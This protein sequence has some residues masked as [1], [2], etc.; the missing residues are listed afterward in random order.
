MAIISESAYPTFKETISKKELEEIYTPIPVE[1][2][3]AK[4]VSRGESVLC[5]LI[6]LKAFQKLGYFIPFNKIP[7]IIIEHISYCTKIKISN[8]T[9]SKYNSSGTKAR[10]VQQIRD[11]LN[12]KQF[13]S[14][15]RHL[16]I[17]AM[18][19]AAKTK[20]EPL[21]LINIAIEELIRNYYELPFFNSLERAAKRVRV[22]INRSYYKAI[23][24]SIDNI[25]REKIDKIIETEEE[26]Q[27]TYWN[28]LKQDPSNPTVNHLKDLVKHLKWLKSLN[29]SIKNI[30]NIPYVKIKQFALEAKTLDASKMKQ[31]ESF[32]RY[33]LMISLIYIQSSSTVD[34]IAEMLIKR[35]MLI[36][37]KGKDALDKYRK[38]HIQI[39]DKLISTLKNVVIAYQNVGT[40]EEKFSAIESILAGENQNILENCEAHLSFSGN[41]YYSFL[42]NYF[43]SHRIV[44]FDIL[45]N[46]KL[47]STNQDIST[48]EAIK[49]LQANECRRSDYIETIRIENKGKK[50]EKR[51]PLLNLSW[52]SELW[53]KLITDKT[54][55][56]VFPEKI[57]RRHFE[58]C[59]FTQIMWELKS[60][61]LYIEG[62]DNYSDFRE[63]LISL[64][65][66]E[67]N[68]VLFSKQ[69]NLPFESKDFIKTVKDMMSK[70]IS[71]TDK[72]FPDNQYVKIVNKEPIISKLEKIKYPEQ[73]KKIDALIAERLAP[74]NILDLISDTNYWLNWTKHFGLLSG[75]ES[76]IENPIERYLLSAFCYG[77]N[78]GPTQLARSFGDL[79]RKHISWI[80]Q[81]H[82]TEEKIENATFNIINAFHSLPLP[83]HWGTGLNAA[84]D[85]T[86]IDLYKSNIFAEGHIRYGGYG[87][88]GY[89]L[90][91]DKYIALFSHFIPCGAWEGTYLIDLLMNSELLTT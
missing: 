1:I 64:E 28:K 77:C 32:K 26:T 65:D 44:L 89:Y 39:T 90:V 21:D 74:I 51:I 34:D 80:N 45:K 18:S 84:T 86:Q 20:D 42:W 71:E 72:S 3:Y 6:M 63:Q 58:V 29:I 35:M 23:S 31:M 5:F 91:S 47:R 13:D 2:E 57:N 67:K 54:N 36:H 38:E 82:I 52:I 7:N 19:T 53:W 79:T 8:D 17:S 22:L 70:T 25:T 14:S 49:F 11:Y 76:K 66:Y 83:K 24:E 33:S 46:L 30:K 81:H 69:I 27:Y 40:V 68:K 60:G 88:L 10:H 41:N 75:F 12:V 87:A 62:G 85:G 56:D 78:I 48:E 43:K 73:K 4:K 16:I 55:R 37:R 61:D 9:I 50:D 59:L 15:A